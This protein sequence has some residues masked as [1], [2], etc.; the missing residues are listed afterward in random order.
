MLFFNPQCASEGFR[1][2]TAGVQVF[3]ASLVSWKVS[4]YSQRIVR[5]FGKLLAFTHV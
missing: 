3:K 5:E 1:E 2:V 4:P